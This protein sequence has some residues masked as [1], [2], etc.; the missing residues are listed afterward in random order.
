MNWDT[1][2]GKWTQLTGSVR[3]QW[4]KLTDDDIAEAKGNRDQLIGKI[5]E[6]YGDARR[7]EIIDAPS[8]G[9]AGSCPAL[10]NAPAI[11]AAPW[12]RAKEAGAI[13]PT[14]KA[15]PRLAPGW[16]VLED[17]V[18]AA[19]AS[20][21]PATARDRAAGGSNRE[22]SGLAFHEASGGCGAPAATTATSAAACNHAP[23]GCR[24]ACGA[25]VS[26]ATAAV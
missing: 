25:R 26:H 19:P 11:D 21:A 3:E 15:T 16:R 4:G 22:P 12:P 7:T 1:I 18:S 5:Q 10:A 2:E 14:T 6:K 20:S 17:S 13:R 24:A 9:A 23:I 8:G